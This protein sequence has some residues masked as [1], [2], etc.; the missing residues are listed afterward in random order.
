MKKRLMLALLAVATISSASLLFGEVCTTTTVPVVE[1]GPCDCIAVSKTFYSVRPLFQIA[2]PE[3]EVLFRN[4]FDIHK[5]EQRGT[6]Q[7]ALYGSQSLNPGHIATYFGPDCKCSNV[8]LV[9][10]S[11]Q[12]SGVADI[13]AGNFNIQTVDGNFKSQITFCPKRKEVGLGISYKQGFCIDWCNKP[14]GLWFEINAPISHVKTTMGLNEYIINNGEGPDFDLVPT[15]DAGQNVNNIPGTIDAPVGSMV[16]ALRQPQWKYGRIDKD[17]KMNATRLAKL[18]F[19]FGFEGLHRDDAHLETFFGVTVPTGNRVKS[20]NLF[21]PIVGHNH[22]FGFMFGSNMGLELWEGP[23]DNKMMIEFAVNGIYFIK[24]CQR[25]LVDLV[26][27]PW[28]RYM[29][30]YANQAQAQQAAATHDAV[31]HTPGVNIL[32]LPVNVTPGFERIYNTGLVYQHGCFE[33]EVGYNF[34]ARSSECIELRN[35]WVE[36]PALVSYLPCGLGPTEGCTDSVQLIN[37]DFDNRNALPVADYQQNIIKVCDLDLDSA[38]HPSTLTH[39]VYANAGARFCS[40]DLPMFAGIGGSYEFSWDNV[41]LNRF[42]VWGKWG[43]SF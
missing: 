38:S 32:A 9:S 15:N 42:T 20:I 35:R 37:N 33:G 34:F 31:L 13:L 17:C 36:G 8:Y 28:S 1:G 12:D 6:L 10:E 40:C 29:R 39:T 14:V 41:G 11:T 27:K 43:V 19:I 23:C 26:N 21:E 2:S 7:L 3:H 22:H 4:Q 30:M 5:K 18:D 24:N 25:R 16:E